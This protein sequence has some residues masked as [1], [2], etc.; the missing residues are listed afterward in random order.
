LLIFRPS[1]VHQPC[2]K[3]C[4]GNGRFNENKIAGQYTAWNQRISFPIRC[5]SAGQNF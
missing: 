3:I 4:L 1:L 5:T 2:A